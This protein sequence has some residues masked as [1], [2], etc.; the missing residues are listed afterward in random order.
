MKA[1]GLTQELVR[2]DTINPQSPEKPCAAIVGRLLEEAGFTVAFHDFAP[3]R[4]S[5]VARR[6]GASAPLCFAG[7]L[8][9][10]NIAYI[11]LNGNWKRGSPQRIVRGN[12]FP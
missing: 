2:I 12:R 10:L 3:G 7:H 1:V 4:T 5:V 11:N 8:D 9:I 6:D